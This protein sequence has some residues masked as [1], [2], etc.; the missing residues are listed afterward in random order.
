MKKVTISFIAIS[1]IFAFAT[2]TIAYAQG[3]DYLKKTKSELT[4]KT[5]KITDQD[6]KKTAE[7]L[8]KF[9]SLQS[10]KTDSPQGVNS[11][12]NQIN[13]A[14]SPIAEKN[15]LITPSGLNFSKENGLPIFVSGNFLKAPASKPG[16]GALSEKTHSEYLSLNKE[17]FQIQ[18][19]DKELRPV[20]QITDRDGL[21]HVRLQQY[22]K[23]IPVWGKEIVM[24]YDAS[25]KLY[26]VNGRYEKTI[27]K[28]ENAKYSVNERKALEYASRDLMKSVNI[29]RIDDELKRL[30]NYNGPTVEKFVWVDDISRKAYYAWMIEIRP[31]MV[32]KWR[33]F[34][35]AQTGGIL[36]KYNA[37]PHDGPATATAT[38]ANGNQRSINVY[39]QNGQYLMVDATKPMFDGDAQNPKGI[40]MTMTNNNTDMSQ[41]SQPSVFA[42]AN[43]QWA[44][45]FSVSAHYS[46]GM[47]YDYYKNTFNRNSL[48]NEGMNMITILH[49][50]ENSQSFDNAY[51]NGSFVVLG[52][53]GQVT[54]GWP[55]ALDFTAHEFTHGV[56]TFTVDLEYKNQSGALNEG[57]ADWG[58]CMVD[59]D[60]WQMGEDI[61]KANYFPTGCM[62]DLADPHNGGTQG[63]NNWLPAHMDEFMN[64]SLDQDNG[65]V[66][67]NCG[68]INKATYLI[69]NSIGR[70][71][72]EQIYYKTLN[73]KYITKQAKFIDMRLG[74]VKAAEE[75]YGAGSTEVN[76][77]KTA[78]DQVGIYN[79]NET[80]PDPDLPAVSGDEFV[81]LVGSADLALYIAK[82]VIEDVNTDI[83][84][85]TSTTVYADNAG[86]ITI[87]ENG[88]VIL[89]IDGSN[90]VRGI[91][92]DGSGEEVI[93][94]TGE[95]RTMAVSPN[96]QYLA[97]TSTD[98]DNLIYIFDLANSTFKQVE[99]Y[100]PSTG[101]DFNYTEPLF[102]NTLTWSIDN[103]TIIYDA[104][105]YKFDM[106]G[107]EE[108]YF[109]INAMDA[110]SKA[111]YRIFPPQPSGINI[112]S[113]DFAKTSDHH[114][115]F[116]V[117]D[118]NE[119]MYYLN[120]MNL[121]DGTVQNIVYSDET[122]AMFS[123]PGYS[124]QDNRLIFQV[125]GPQTQQFSIYQA[126]LGD[127][128]ISL[129][130][131]H[132]LY[133]TNAGM[134]KW[135]AIGARPE[136]AEENIADIYDIKVFPNPT[137][138][139][140]DININL[141]HPDYVSIDLCSADGSVLCNL[142]DRS[143]ESAGRFNATF[144][145]RLDNGALLANGIYFLKIRIG[146]NIIMKKLAVIR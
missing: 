53:G 35:D 131:N 113:P 133:L 124:T 74:C 37:T 14:S 41:Q 95:W 112:G 71:K 18:D 123:S 69:G 114:L 125:Y 2:T 39:L 6:L 105:N 23:D 38:D 84:L 31:N 80:K 101:D 58:G 62:R 77:V 100:Q 132:A 57:F 59:R 20:E 81:A 60:D 1:L 34:I 32:D 3:F 128:K 9:F 48:D 116:Q 97:A 7:N 26:L 16:D 47:I 36:E 98:M 12:F 27:E 8:S 73:N 66:H 43:N 109:D 17:L 139:Q 56:V 122:Q 96:G 145:G 44:D 21:T 40:I 5:S 135:F 107:N 70:D 119:G 28:L 67:Y 78:F 76:A 55:P 142:V 64:M 82:T 29:I 33:Y 42:S 19:P 46:T 130:G 11:T 134:P 126:P 103:Q 75:L 136:S 108:L 4:A 88:S 45:A 121:F 93:S 110:A 85:L 138:G 129:D 111:I 15:L 63:D 50:T 30:I 22:C 52:D 61:V 49:V 94:S 106:N 87:P 83:G 24:H 54:N 99:I 127:D 104:V 117:Y 13:E 118:E 146:N 91:L 89:F 86:T 10:K 144:N 65:G 25:N 120:G 79:G 90:Y 115:V 68:I 51:W 141:R 143:F 140:A 137:S 72:L 102:A 92:P